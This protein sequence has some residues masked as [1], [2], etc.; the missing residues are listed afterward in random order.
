M[1]TQ[2]VGEPEDEG[3]WEIALVWMLKKWNMIEDIGLIWLR[4]WTNGLEFLG[5]C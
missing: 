5:Q 4:V 1:H 3:D 2:L